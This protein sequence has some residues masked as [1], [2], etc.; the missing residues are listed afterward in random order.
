MKKGKLIILEG[1]DGTGKGT[2]FERIVNIFKLNKVKY[3]VFDFPRYYSS[4]WGKQ[5]GRQL[6]GEFGQ[7]T[8]VSPYFRT[9]FFILD[10][11]GAA[12]DIKKA[13]DK[14]KIVLCNR[15]TT[16]QIFQAAGFDTTKEKN[17]YWKWLDEAAYKELGIIPPDLVIGLY[18]EPEV[19][20]QN[21]LKKSKREYSKAK[22]DLN[23]KNFNLQIKAA[24][25]LKRVCK[26]NKNWF[27]LKVSNKKQMYD[28]DKITNE[29]INT[30]QENLKLV[31]TNKG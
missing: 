13:L 28:I 24:N 6:T 14:G 16:S 2:Q 29:I 3:E 30:I 25:E 20:F 7:V 18:A 26:I 5:V 31:L 21:V 19:A 4:F 1:I 9:M 23:E 12:K 8:E 11:A 17:A 22:Q 15:Y 27:L 10:Q